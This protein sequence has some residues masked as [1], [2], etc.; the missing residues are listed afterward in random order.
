MR[1]QASALFVALPFILLACAQAAD[2]SSFQ[3]ATGATTA[4]GGTTTTGAS[5]RP[6]VRATDCAA[7]ELCAQ[8]AGDIY[9]A[10]DCGKGQACARGSACTTVSGADGSQIDV[11]TTSTCGG[12]GGNAGAGGSQSTGTGT[13]TGNSEVCGSLDGPDLKACCSSCVPGG[14]QPCQANGCYG[15]WW[16][17]TQS[18]KC[19][20]APA[21]GC[22]AGAG[23]SGQTTSSSTSSSTGAGGNAGSVT[24]ISGGKL[25]TLSFAVV[26]DTRPPIDD[27]TPG[28]PKAIVQQIWADVA[29]Q[30]PRPAFAIATGDYLFAKPHGSQAGPQLDRYLAARAAFAGPLFPALGN[31]ECTGATASNCGANAADGITNNYTAFMTKMLQPLGVTQPYYVVDIASTT[32]KWTA[33][34]VFVAANAW[35]QA[36]A[37]WLGGAL[38][39]PTTYTFVV[40]HEG[41]LVA[42]APGVTPSATILA[43]HPYTMLIVGHTHTYAYYAKEKQLVVGNGGAPLTGNVNYG[44]VVARQRGDGALVFKSIDYASG[45][46]VQQFNVKADGTLTN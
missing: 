18:C 33:K 40:R 12:A 46:I 1:V 11:C 26:G 10:A 41:T 6:C 21:T 17:N 13:G 32:G 24:G 3:T 2:T 5:C 25:D 27:D 30:N 44:Y 4:A 9:C 20:A 39:Q 19:Q 15:G 23:G 31:H 28:Y 45:A 8:F 43:Q 22:G 29:A 35:S 37:T 7:G 14:A 36:Q 42:Q 38:A 34:F 16:C